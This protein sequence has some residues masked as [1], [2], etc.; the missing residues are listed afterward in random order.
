MLTIILIVLSSLLAVL[1]IAL[2]V[3]LLRATRRLVQY[4]DVFQMLVDDIE[5]NLQQFYKMS[6]S[7]LL[8]NDAEIVQA[9][10]NMMIM[11]D[12][13]D[14]FLREMEEVSGL[15]LRTPKAPPLSTTSLNQLK[16]Q[17]DKL[18]KGN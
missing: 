14:E 13:L 10:R 8:G 6:Q 17:V 16:A 7:S 15:R 4:D 5:T 3:F 9:H 1:A 2:M 18:D 11:R 12:R